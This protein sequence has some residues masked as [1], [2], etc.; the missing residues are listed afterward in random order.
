MTDASATVIPR[1]SN[2]FDW[3]AHR[4]APR[5]RV[6]DLACGT[7]R[8]ALAAA[9][10]GAVVTAVDRDAA[11]L[12]LGRRAAEEAGL[13]VEWLEADLE[14]PWPAWS[15]FDAVLVFNYLD[16]SGMSRLL[17]RVAPG[18][19]LLME[20]FRTDQRAEGWGPARDE[21]LL[22]PG[23]LRRLIAPLEVLHGREAIEPTADGRWRHI[24]SICAFR[25]R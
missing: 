2:W 7:G 14:A 1:P 6:L 17:D 12:A 21:H 25:P 19:I 8:H 4:I 10:L 11:R 18:G 22:R 3:H 13:D 23:E 5:M 20:T 24:A 9:R 15:V 16:R